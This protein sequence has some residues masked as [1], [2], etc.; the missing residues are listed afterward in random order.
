MRLFLPSFMSGIEWASKLRFSL[1]T[2]RQTSTK[3]TFVRIFTGLTVIG[4]IA[5]L[6]ILVTGSV[7]SAQNG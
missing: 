5:G 4:M 1:V 2:R 6:V 7:L 3:S